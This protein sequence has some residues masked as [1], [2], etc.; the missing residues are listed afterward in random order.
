MLV[1][2]VANIFLNNSRVDI[3]QQLFGPFLAASCVSLGQAASNLASWKF[4]KQQ[5]ARYSIAG[6]TTLV[7]TLTVVLTSM[8]RQSCFEWLDLGLLC[9]VSCLIVAVSVYLLP[10]LPPGDAPKRWLRFR[11]GF[12]VLAAVAI[13][14][15]QQAGWCM[16]W[17]PQ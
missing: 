15:F 8:F 13:L 2:A 4:R 6:L 12:S 9:L 17:L 7:V 10:T 16:C 5:A 11:A 1:L 3:Y 14:I